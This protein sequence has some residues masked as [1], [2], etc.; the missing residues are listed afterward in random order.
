MCLA[1]FSNYG[2]AL[3]YVPEHLKNDETIVVAAMRHARSPDTAQYM[4]RARDGDYM[5][6]EM[7][8]NR[9]VREAAGV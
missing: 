5:S 6:A 7:K 2:G 8:R 4:F 1:A 3:F 9:R